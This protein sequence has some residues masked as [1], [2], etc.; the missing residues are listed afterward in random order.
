MTANQS[1]DDNLSTLDTAPG[2]ASRSAWGRVCPPLLACLDELPSTAP[3]PTLRT[4]MANER[5]FGVFFISAAQIWRQLALVLGEQQARASFGLTNVLVMFGDPKDRAF[6]QEISDLVGQTRVSRTTWQTGAMAA[7]RSLR[8]TL[9]SSGRRDPPALGAA[10]S[11]D[12]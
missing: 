4:R 3:L 2:L 1:K 7:A 9:R 5:A 6:N 11:G 12:R 10:C 8:K